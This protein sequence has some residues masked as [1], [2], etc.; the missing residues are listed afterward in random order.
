MIK[1]NLNNEFF[2][3]ESISNKYVIF[4]HGMVETMEGYYKI[5]DFLVENGIN[6][7]LYNNK[8]HGENARKLGHLDKYDGYKMVQD[9]IEI[10]KYIKFTYNSENVIIVGHSMGTAL[11]RG[12][13]KS[14]K[15]DKVVLNGSPSSIS[16]FTSNFLFFIY[17]FINNKKESKLFNKLVFS[18]YNSSVKD[19]ATPND[20]VCSNTDYIAK[21][22]QNKYCGIIGT[23]GFYQEIIR[24]MAIAKEKSLNSTKVLITSGKEDPVTKMGINCN[25]LYKRL[26]KQGCECEIKTYDKMRHFIYDEINCNE[27]YN[28]LLKFISGG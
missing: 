2:L 7:I 18:K 28:D 6:V 8:G 27:C 23:G 13:M 1:I 15:F 5:K 10:N 4:V 9:V 20:W 22:N 12:A 17:L 26:I 14:V 24:I 11:V 21:Y 16:A 25:Q 3:Y 19:P